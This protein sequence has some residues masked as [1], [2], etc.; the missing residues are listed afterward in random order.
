[1]LTEN[2]NVKQEPG[3]R[4]RWFESDRLEL[5][6][7]YGAPGA[8]EGFQLCHDRPDGKHALTWRSPSGFTYDR[9]N[10]GDTNPFK[11]ETPVLLP[12]GIAPWTE[13]IALF[14]TEAAQIDGPLRELILARL[15]ARS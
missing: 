11:N 13:L 4:R 10:T 6:V 14:Q 15:Q 5:I 2:R 7:W 8:V 1:M 3:G 9:V 12:D